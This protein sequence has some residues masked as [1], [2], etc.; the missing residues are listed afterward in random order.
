M[1][2]TSSVEREKKRQRMVAHFAEKRKA[3]KAIAKDTT[4]AQE[5]RFTARLRLAEMP[6]NSSKARLHN[7]CI[8][9]GRARGVE[10]RFKICRIVLRDLASRGLIPGMVKS[11][12]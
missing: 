4:L 11:S 3:L 10:S 2:K 7:R 9:T 6:R 5:D 1:A 12:W 8:V